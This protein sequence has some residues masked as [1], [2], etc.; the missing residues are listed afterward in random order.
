MQNHN[1][2]PQPY[3]NDQHWDNSNIPHAQVFQ[4]EMQNCHSYGANIPTNIPTDARC[5]NQQNSN[6]NNHQSQSFH[7]LMSN[8]SSPNIPNPT[9]TFNTCQHLDL[10]PLP[11]KS[12]YISL[13]TGY[14]KNCEAFI[15]KGASNRQE[16]RYTKF[17]CG[18]DP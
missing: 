8:N 13:R 15:S 10:Y 14:C 7:N 12:P 2:G 16:H 9:P 4:T 1:P 17:K 3:G 6:L 11:Y 5:E 18:M